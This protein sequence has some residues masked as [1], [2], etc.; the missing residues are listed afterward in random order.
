[1]RAKREKNGPRLIAKRTLGIYG[2][3]I[4]DGVVHNKIVVLLIVCMCFFFVL[5]VFECAFF[6]RKKNATTTKTP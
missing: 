1:M 3:K 4:E 6:K 2:H 5:N